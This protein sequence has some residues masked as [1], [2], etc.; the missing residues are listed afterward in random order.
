MVS[1]DSQHLGSLPTV[2]R[3]DDL[4]D[5]DETGHRQV[6]SE[7]DESNHLDDLGEVLTLRRSQWVRLEER[8]YRVAQ[9]SES[10]DLKLTEVLTMVVVSSVDVDLPATE[11][12]NHVFQHTPTRC[13]LDDGKGGLHLPAES[14]R[15]IAKDGTAE[16]AF[17][18]YE[19]HQ[20]IVGEESFLLIVRTGRIFTAHRLTLKAG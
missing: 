20:P 7:F 14:H 12:L 10:K 6:R 11:E 18:I 5:L 16:T 9:V 17:P 1:E 2:H 8:D 3:L 19:S 15:R 13:S 4:R